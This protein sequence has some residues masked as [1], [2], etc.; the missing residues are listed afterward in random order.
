MKLNDEDI[1]TVIS[2]VVIHE[3]ATIFEKT[4]PRIVQNFLIW[5]FMIDQAWMMPQTFRNIE[6]QYRRVFDPISEERPR[7]VRCAVYLGEAMGS[8]MSKSYVDKYF[9]ES[10]RNEVP[11]VIFRFEVNLNLSSSLVALSNGYP[12]RQRVR[13]KRV[14]M[15]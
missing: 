3:I 13:K 6:Q 11:M 5:R 14:E 4:S 1:V 7:S 9:N 8:V 12:V 10:I 2:P 15:C